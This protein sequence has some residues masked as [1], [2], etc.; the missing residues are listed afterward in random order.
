MKSLSLLL[1]ALFLSSANYSQDSIMPILHKMFP[2][3]ELNSDLYFIKNK[4][5]HK[6]YKYDGLVYAGKE[7]FINLYDSIENVIT[8][9]EKMSRQD[10]YFL[11]AP[12]IELLQDDVSIYSLVGKYAYDS[13]SE[14]YLPFAEKTVMPFEV[15]VFKDTV[16][17]MTDT[18]D[19]Y[20]SRLISINDI[21]ASE[22]VSGIL[23]YTS[24]SKYRYYQ[25]HKYA[26][27]KM[28]YSSVISYLLFG[29]Q[30]EVEIKFEQ[31]KSG[32]ILSKQLNLL[33]I[34]DA[35]FYDFVKQENDSLSWYSLKFE[36]DHAILRIE[37][38]PPG[39]LRVTAINDI[40][41]KIHDSQSIS[42]I[43]DISDCSWSYDNFWIILLNYLTEGDISLYEYQK[44]PQDLG[45]FTKKRIN[46]IN[47]I[48]GKFADI[49]KY[50]LFNG[51]IY[52]I[53]GAS[54][55][56]AAVRFADILKYNNISDK[57]FGAETL[58]KTT[59]YDFYNS[60]YLPATG[61]ALGLS[62]ALYYAL[63]KNL[64][65]DGLIPDVEVIP[66]NG[67]EFLQ[68]IENKLVIDKVIKLIDSENINK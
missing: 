27:F 6:R 43:I 41:K 25:K 19:L 14:A 62:T 15:E 52:L 53:T 50:Y 16:Y 39:E 56:S 68:N 26:S 46:N 28:Y 48:L 11:T 18:L 55:K 65:T 4:V 2:A 64:N 57:I 58:T 8:Q 59:Q 40:F 12:L 7:K 44:R 60:H 13:R 67:T 63:D 51:K 20:Q 9:K 29:F 23:K 35:S 45:K 30:N 36:K 32:T 1:I 31:N 47:Y 21:P 61:I 34:G 37:S 54:T 17:I 33:P 38:M 49:N 3:H 66:A 5:I 22:I 10:F 24:F 42:L